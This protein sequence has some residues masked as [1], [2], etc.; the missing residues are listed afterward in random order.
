[1]THIDRL[2][3]RS[4]RTHLLRTTS[5]FTATLVLKVANYVQQQPWVIAQEAR[6]AFKPYE[7]LI[8][9]VAFRTEALRLIDLLLSR[10]DQ[11]RVLHLQALTG[12]VVL[13]SWLDLAV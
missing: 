13:R 2:D 1:M 5:L 7:A 11:C 12:R 6:C 4:F 10:D 9:L 8:C 3:N